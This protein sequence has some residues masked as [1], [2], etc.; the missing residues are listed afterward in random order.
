MSWNV[1]IFPRLINFSFRQTFWLISIVCRRKIEIANNSRQDEIETDIEF[2]RSQIV[3]LLYILVWS[4]PSSF[5]HSLVFNAKARVFVCQLSNSK[6][7]I[8]SRRVS[9]LLNPN[10]ISFSTFLIHNYPRDS[11]E[12]LMC[13]VFSVY[14]ENWN[15]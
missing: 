9:Q 12:S 13:R 15:R 14:V 1:K 8:S 7:E 6:K 2:N 4:L 3:E 5:H 11:L 10:S